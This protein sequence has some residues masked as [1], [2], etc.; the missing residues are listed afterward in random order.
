[1][2]GRRLTLNSSAS[3]LSYP[4]NEM[5]DFT[6]RLPERVI[7]SDDSK[8]ALTEIIL[9]NQIVNVRN[10]LTRGDDIKKNEV[11]VYRPKVLE[12]IPNAGYDVA[13]YGD[14]LQYKSGWELVHK[15]EIPEG[16][17]DDWNE[18]VDIIHEQSSWDNW[19]DPDITTVRN[20]E[21]NRSIGKRIEF[22]FDKDSNCVTL[23]TRTV[24]GVRLGLDT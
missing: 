19:K 24:Y 2:E 8:V 5:G 14:S 3:M 7:E 13:I 4:D 21:Q 11:M 16:C 10:S 23:V 20:A 18:F 22:T 12:K 15:F 17:Y 9:P 6:I 1:M